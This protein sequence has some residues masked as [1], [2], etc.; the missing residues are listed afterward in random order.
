M[1]A[2]RVDVER[3]RTTAFAQI[4]TSP[5]SVYQDVGVDNPGAAEVRIT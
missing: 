1:S 3:F 5:V 2:V 4:H